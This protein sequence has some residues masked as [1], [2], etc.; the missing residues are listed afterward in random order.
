MRPYRGPLV[1]FLERLL[2]SDYVFKESPG[3]VI[4]R[5]APRLIGLTVRVEQKR[6][7]P[8]LVEGQ[9]KDAGHGTGINQASI[10]ER[11]VLVSTLSGPTGNF[12][13]AF[14]RPNET[15]WLT[16]SKE[17]YRDTT[18]ALLLPV[19]IGSKNDRQRY[20]FYPDGDEGGLEHTSFGRLFTSTRQRIQ[21]INLAGFFA[22]SPYQI[23]FTPGLSSQGLFNSQVVNQVSLNIVGGHTAGVNGAEVGGVFNISE[24][25]VSYFQVAGLFNLVGGSMRGV[26]VAGASNTVVRRVWGVQ[27]AGVTNRGGAVRGMQLS[28]IFNVAEKVHG[29]QLALVNIAD[30]S[31]YPIGLVN[32]VKNGSKSLAAGVDDSGLAQLTFRSGGRV[33]Y[34]LIGV[35]HYVSGHPVACTLDAGIGVHI[36]RAGGFGID[37]EAISRVNTDFK[38]LGDHQLSLRL[39]PQFGFDRHW[40]IAAGPTLSYTLPHT[41]NGTSGMLRMGVYGGVLYRW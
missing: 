34:G 2:G 18:V 38:R 39:L 28:G 24:Q 12:R 10:Y 20:W 17:N 16:I 22:Y 11:N 36:V 31:D 15:I 3:Y 8:L 32:L 5:Y 13:L 9:V 37:A 4:I 30:S 41:G 14:R 33:L 1:G 27:A 7:R 25:D 26:Q 40:G 19:Q 6:G 35:G 21:R 23:S 29:V